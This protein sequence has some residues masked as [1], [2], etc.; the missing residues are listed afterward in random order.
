[1]PSPA[2]PVELRSV[3][4][5]NYREEI[6]EASDAFQ[7]SVPNC[8]GLAVDDRNL[9]HAH[10]DVWLWRSRASQPCG[11]IL[12]LCQADCVDLDRYASLD[13]RLDFG[14]GCAQNHDCT[15][16]DMTLWSQPTGCATCSWLYLDLD[17]DVHVD[18]ENDHGLLDE[19]VGVHNCVD[20][21]GNPIDDYAGWDAVIVMTLGVDHAECDHDRV[22]HLRTAH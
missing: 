4:P 19:C 20:H 8:I 12:D 7:D 14:I 13:D 9:V 17:V 11:C 18:L 15:Q 3:S 6:S 10:A 1:M 22:C 21:R 2:V 5:M 16:S